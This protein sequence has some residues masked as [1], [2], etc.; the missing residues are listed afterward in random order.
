MTYLHHLALEIIIIEYQ[1]LALRRL[2]NFWLSIMIFWGNI[3]PTLST[4]STNIWRSLHI[5]RASHR[6]NNVHTFKQFKTS[7][8]P[9]EYIALNLSLVPIIVVTL[10]ILNN[11]ILIILNSKSILKTKFNFVFSS[12][13]AIES[14]PKTL[15]KYENISFIA[16]LC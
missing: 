14:M 6:N 7:V 2:V 13:M 8:S 3:S 9:Y 15:C 12:K 16:S 1:V 4:S 5:Q 11:V 10:K